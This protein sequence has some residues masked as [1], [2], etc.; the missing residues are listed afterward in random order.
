MFVDIFHID[1]A[2]R[3]YILNRLFPRF[4]LN[5]RECRMELPL[6]GIRHQGIP[7]FST[8]PSQNPSLRTG[9][10]GKKSD[11]CTRPFGFCGK[12]FV[13]GSQLFNGGISP[14]RKLGNPGTFFG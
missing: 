12:I 13:Q 9:V 2:F 4:N 8:E 11:T 1:D 14:W 7:A 3:D 5:I 10:P 6:I